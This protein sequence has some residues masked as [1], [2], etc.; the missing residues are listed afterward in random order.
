MAIKG[1]GKTRRRTV[2]AGPKPVYVEPPKALW[3]RRWVQLTALCVVLAGIGI[4][5]AAILIHLGNQHHKEQV[6]ATREKERAIVGQF[7]S[8]VDQALVPV[9]QSFQ[10]TKV[11]FPDL[12]KQF[13]ALKPSEPLSKDVLQLARSSGKLAGAAARTLQKIPATSLVSGHPTLVPLID[14]QDFLVQSLKVYEQA[15]RAV[16]AA[17]KA[18]GDARTALFDQAGNLLPVGADLFNS[19]YQRLVNVRGKLGIFPP[20]AA[21]PAPSPPAASPSAAPSSTPSATAS[22]KGSGKKGGGSKKSGTT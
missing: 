12:T 9:T 13:S 18:S 10:Q 19:G 7:G 21:P 16:L 11:P 6:K 4:A 2:A 3:R 8:Q 15:A 1:K 22:G 5:A 20:P 14:S 17:D